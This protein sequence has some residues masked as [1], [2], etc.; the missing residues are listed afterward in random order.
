LTFSGAQK[1]PAQ[2]DAECLNGSDGRDRYAVFPII[3]RAADNKKAAAGIPDAAFCSI[4]ETLRELDIVRGGCSV[5]GRPGD[6]LLFQALR[7]STIGAEDFDGRVRDGIGYRLLAM[8]T[9]PAKNGTMK[10]AEANGVSEARGL[11]PRGAFRML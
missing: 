3:R 8:T 4:A 6:D 1:E 10:Q 11:D 9:R 5:L 2:H 7:L